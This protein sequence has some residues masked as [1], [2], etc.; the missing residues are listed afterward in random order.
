MYLSM[1][2]QAVPVAVGSVSS[3]AESIIAFRCGS[4]TW[5]QLEL[6][7]GTLT[8]NGTYRTVSGLSKSRTQPADG[9]TSISG[10]GTPQYLPYIADWSTSARWTLKPS[11]VRAPSMIW[12]IAGEF[13]PLP[14]TTWSVAVPVYLPL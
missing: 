14:E 10:F 12:A 13:P 1:F 5:L 4:L 8:P 3:D 2:P 11:D 9:Q 6:L 7:T